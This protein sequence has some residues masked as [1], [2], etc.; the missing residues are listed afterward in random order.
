MGEE[1]EITSESERLVIFA[2]G[3]ENDAI[4]LSWGQRLRISVARRQLRLI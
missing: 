3:V 2:D 1:L 4:E